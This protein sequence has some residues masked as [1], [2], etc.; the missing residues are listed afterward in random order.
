V[1]EVQFADGLDAPDR[2]A[3]GLAAGQLM[4][5]VAGALLAYALIRSS[6]PAAVSAP[7]ALTLGAIAATLGW[8]RVAGRP[9]LDWA[10]FVWSYA[11]QPRAG[12]LRIE[13][14][15]PVLA[16]TGL[17]VPTSSSAV[18]ATRPAHTII[19]LRPYVLCDN[20]AVAG[21]S[22]LAQLA[23]SQ[24]PRPAR[25]LRIGGARRIALFS[26]KGGTGR[27]M[28]ASEL[29]CLLAA[30]ASGGD[31]P[32][33]SRVALLDLDVRS[34]SIGL[35][36]GI[37]HLTVMDFALAPLDD[38]RVVE[39]MVSHASGVEVL[40]GTSDPTS[41]DWPLNEDLVREILRELDLEGFD[42]V[43][44]DV[45][46]HLSPLARAVLTS[47]DDVF[48]VVTA[49]AAGVQDAYRSTEALRR[50]GVRH[51][52]RYLLNRARS[53]VDLSI[54][55]ADL[56]GQLVA[57]IPE[58]PRVVDAENRHQVV[59]ESGGEAAMALHRLARRLSREQATQ[60]SR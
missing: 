27:S 53:G 37:T 33:K 49:T 58:D 24:P 47:A 40:L 30:P 57:E 4:I 18:A 51:Q 38:R 1:E 7:A 6:L 46:A 28:L 32:S 59:A 42:V 50:I 45:S 55:M 60:W 5:V 22:G 10:I 15:S 17:V 20:G 25:A 9:A 23:R 34:P 26:L 56:G 52:L 54:A 31:A 44:T 12:L 41:S 8:L 13:T 43:V 21:V 29:A 11:T 14:E 19:P 39:F 3:F 16:G 48:V 35:R 2:L 36:L